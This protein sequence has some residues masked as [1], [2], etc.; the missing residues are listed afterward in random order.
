MVSYCPTLHH[1]VSYCSYNSPLML[2]PFYTLPYPSPTSP[3]NSPPKPRFLPYKPPPIQHLSTYHHYTTITLLYAPP[4]YMRVP[5]KKP[6]YYHG[7]THYVTPFFPSILIKFSLTI[8]PSPNTLHHLSNTHTN[9]LTQKN[10][11]HNLF[12]KVPFFST[13]I[14]P[15]IP[16]ISPKPSTQSL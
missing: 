10:F 13:T 14:P 8:S 4:P 16:P 12:L 6:V 2:K 11:F 15:T 3:T 5:A 7:F 1:T 9:S